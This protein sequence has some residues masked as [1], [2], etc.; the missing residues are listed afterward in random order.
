MKVSS[1]LLNHVLF[2]DYTL[3]ATICRRARPVSIGTFGAAL[4]KTP[5]ANDT[6]PAPNRL[7]DTI[8]D[9]LKQPTRVTWQF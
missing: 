8:A 9:Y 4:D 1:A 7:P 6:R 5:R 2:W 3:S